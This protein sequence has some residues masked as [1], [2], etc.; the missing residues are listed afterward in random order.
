MFLV[1]ILSQF[2]VLYCDLSVLTAGN[3]S[4]SDLMALI[5]GSAGSGV[6]RLVSERSQAGSSLGLWK[7]PAE[8][9]RAGA[10]CCGLRSQAPRSG[11]A[12]T[13]PVPLLLGP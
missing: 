7:G 5:N 11:L 1:S 6:L 10:P 13:V 9:G 4:S 8:R 12:R 2:Y 3:F